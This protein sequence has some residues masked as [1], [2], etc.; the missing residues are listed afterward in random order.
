MPSWLAPSSLAGTVSKEAV[1]PSTGLFLDHVRLWPPCFSNL[2]RSHCLNLAA[3]KLLPNMSLCS[4]APMST[5]GLHALHHPP[6][7]P[8]L[9]AHW[10]ADGNTA[11]PLDK[12][13]TNSSDRIPQHR[14]RL[15]TYLLPQCPKSDT[16]SFMWQQTHT[17]LFACK[18]LNLHTH[19]PNKSHI[20]LPMHIY[21][22]CRSVVSVLIAANNFL[23]VFLMIAFWHKCLN[24]N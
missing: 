17:W 6:T 8:H 18:K 1:N 2:I 24:K 9:P 4:T 22:K 13:V 15:T 20:F 12:T 19:L 11:N 3:L 16:F 21:L 14:R 5:Q 7:L 10:S 23:N